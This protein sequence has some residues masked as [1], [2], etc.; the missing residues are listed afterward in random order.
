MISPSMAVA[1]LALAVACFA[2]L[3]LIAIYGKLRQIEAGIGTDISGYSLAA[4][5]VAPEAVWPREGTEVSIVALLDEN[6]VLCQEMWK[7]VAEFSS[8]EE[9]DGIRY[10]GLV[11][12]GENLLF[13]AEGRL[14]ISL[15]VSVRAEL[16]EG[17]APVLLVVDTEGNIQDRKFIYGDTDVVEIL[18]SAHPHSRSKVSIGS[19]KP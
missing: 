3:G 18:T 10:I 17:Y 13:P 1:L 16:F 2:L 11:P 12:T 14:E 15:D 8:R 19:V 6:C 7:T 4:R 5:R 9:S